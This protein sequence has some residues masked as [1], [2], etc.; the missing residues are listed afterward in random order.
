MPDHAPA[1][2]DLAKLHGPIV[3][4]SA[5]CLAAVTAHPEPTLAPSARA[6]VSGI[7]YAAYLL[8]GWS[9]LLVPAL[10]RSI[11]A[12]FG[13]SD[14]DLGLFYLIVSLGFGIGALGGGFATEK[15]GRRA[16]IAVAALLMGLGIALE[17]LTSAWGIFLLAAVPTGLGS[18]VIDGGMNS[19]VLDLTRRRSGGALNRLHLFFSIGAAASPLVV[20]QLVTAGVDWRAILLATAAG[21]TLVGI[22]F[23]T[24][25]M[26]SGRH[27]PFEAT[28]AG[29]PAP[30]APAASASLVP[31]AILG[32]AIACYVSAEIG[33]SSWLVRFLA[34]APAS[35]ATATLAA[36]WAGVA[37]SRLL[38]SRHADRFPPVTFAAACAG[39]ATATLLGA[40]VVPW[41]PAAMVLFAV[42]GVAF[43]PIYPMIMSIGGSLYSRRRAA[44]TG[45]LAMVATAG[46]VIYPPVM[47]FISEA[48]GLELAMVGAAILVGACGAALLGARMVTQGPAQ[49]GGAA[50]TR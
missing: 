17:G 39:I 44:V 5:L 45:T 31:L 26:P 2:Y 50:V 28:A 10:I 6:R 40:V 29:D 15:I 9:T 43:G 12:D 27:H 11:E 33:T 19:L 42:T 24:H 23:A 13:R 34:A 1:P 8:L 4:R 38:G 49:E 20:G 21:P 37:I 47:G 16:L 3:E 46:S 36:F 25:A 30:S 35:A 18:G 48:A 7:A 14:A 22:G 32:L 41:V